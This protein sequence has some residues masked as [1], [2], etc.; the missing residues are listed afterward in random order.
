M[1]S[2]ELLLRMQRLAL[3]ARKGL[4]VMYSGTL[5]MRRT[6][7]PHQMPHVDALLRLLRGQRAAVRT[8]LRDIAQQLRE[9]RTRF[10]DPPANP[11]AFP[12][13]E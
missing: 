13:L 6:A 10:L 7:L 11:P 9:L 12:M 2:F 4:R 5:A 8:T 3:E 1:D